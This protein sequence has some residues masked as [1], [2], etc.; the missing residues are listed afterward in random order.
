MSHYKLVLVN[1]IFVQHV[2]L[3]FF[4]VHLSRQ[5]HYQP[6]KDSKNTGFLIKCYDM[7]KHSSTINYS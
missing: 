6:I 2:Q 4:I 3:K 7:I 5:F 1:P